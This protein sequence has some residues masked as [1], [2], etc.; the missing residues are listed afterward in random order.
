MQN[1]FA[2]KNLEEKNVLESPPPLENVK[3]LSLKEDTFL[4]LSDIHV[5][6]VFFHEQF[7]LLDKNEWGRSVSGI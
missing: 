7:K 4:I 3:M 5:C 1:I 2:G 6:Q